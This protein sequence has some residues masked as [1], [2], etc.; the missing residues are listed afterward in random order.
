MRNRKEPRNPGQPGRAEGTAESGQP[1]RAEGTAE[2]G[3]PGRAEG[4]AESGQPGRAKGTE[5]YGRLGTSGKRRL[6]DTSSGEKRKE[7]E[8]RNTQ[9]TEKAPEPSGKLR[10]TILLIGFMGGGKTSVGQSL[11]FRANVPFLDTDEMIC[12]KEGRTIPTIFEQQGENA[13]RDMETRLLRELVEEK[14]N[15]KG[16]PEWTP[17]VISVG[18]GLP[19]REENR[20]LM[21]ALG[22][23]I[24]LKASPE[25]LEKRVEGD[26]SRPLLQGGDRHAKILSL[27]AAREAIYEDAADISILT[28]HMTVRET[29]RRILAMARSV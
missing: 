8:E 17:Q 22:R 21:H 9:M 3:Q 25:V 26:Q 16:A 2:S 28:D 4:T 10:E 1:G 27:M 24:Y 20:E 14:E 12:E 23:V 7:K 11:A 5:G 29:A 19:L 13:F 18:G 6:G 15:E